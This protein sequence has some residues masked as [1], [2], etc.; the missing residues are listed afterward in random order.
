M[1]S[2]EAVAVG[3]CSIVLADS[4]SIGESASKALMGSLRGK[5]VIARL[6][7]KCCQGRAVTVVVL[8]EGNEG[9]RQFLDT[10]DLGV[11]QVF[12]GAGE[13]GHAVGSLLAGLGA[14]PSQAADVGIIC[15]H[16]LCNDLEAA[17]QAGRDVL[18]ATEPSGWDFPHAYQLSRNEAG[19]VDRLGAGEHVS[20]GCYQFTDVAAFK[21]VV[22]AAALQ[23]ERGVEHVISAYMQQRAVRAVLSDEVF[24]LATE[25][26]RAHAAD[27][28][29]NAR[30]F[31][32]ITVDRKRGIITK[33]S[34]KVQ[35]LEDEYEWYIGL[36]Q[37]LQPL[38]PRQYS[39][40]KGETPTGPVATLVMEL[41][42]YPPLSE[43]FISGEVP[44]DTWKAIIHKL[45]EVHQKLERHAGSLGP[46]DI[47]MLYL[48]KTLHRV[49]ELLR[50]APY[51][52][53]LW[54]YPEIILNGV[55][56]KNIRY[57]ENQISAAV[58]SLIQD[59]PI[60]I[61]HGDYCFSNILF[62]TATFQCT[63]IDPRGSVREQERTIYG[64]PRYDIAK[65]RHSAVGGYDY[66][67]HGLF[68]LRD[69]GNVFELTDNYP[70]FQ[71]ELTAC[72]DEVTAEFGYDVRQIQLL[73]ALIFLTIIPLH[74]DN[75][76]RQ[77]LF[78]L[79]AV[80]K[81]NELFEEK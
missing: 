52:K 36:P 4:A 28:F 3:G 31:N 22:E 45:F 49:E 75:I 2:G 53:R 69:V 54:S 38:V 46:D 50:S 11:R 10:Y 65:L 6:L 44:L 33:E 34:S 14:V 78:Y 60:T 35:K 8:D 61:V 76:E 15:A 80:K 21:G 30:S 9:L 24:N 7:E 39:F 26:G 32:K 68:N 70:S 62:D 19:L 79:K 23:G 71:E 67:V 17:F 25:E 40:R 41:C 12:P 1:A 47:Q 56:Y 16:M 55:A 81:I 51:W 59:A 29:F 48:H 77:K 37:D 58:D 5:P 64:D 66:A 73:E 13:R 42:D 43:Q 57:F 27:Y 72:F 63:L 74:R 20:V 18:V